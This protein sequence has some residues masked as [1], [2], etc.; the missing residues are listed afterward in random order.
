[1]AALLRFLL[2]V[3]SPFGHTGEI[4]DLEVVGRGRI[5]VP[6]G[7]FAMGAEAEELRAAARMCLQQVDATFCTPALFQ[8]E[9]PARR[10]RLSAYR[11]DATEVTN[12]AYGRCV[13]AGACT[14]ARVQPGDDRFRLPRAPVGSVSW[15]DARDYCRWAGGRLPT[16]AEWERA[17]RGAEGRRFPWGDLWNPH[18]CNHGQTGDLRDREDDGHRFVAPVGS[19]PGGRSPFGL[20]DL[21]GNVLEWVEDRYAEYSP[22]ARFDPVA[23]ETGIDRV[24]RGG[25]WRS[26]GFLARTTTR[27]HL[28]ETA[29]ELDVGFRCAE[30][31]R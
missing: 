9:A 25:S 21:A 6:A 10:V 27:Q 13:S 24:I 22:A 23:T 3:T 11:I 14:P 18:L 15:D 19:F 2:L 30:T 31:V 20:D 4:L 26:P 1:M 29:H 28:P 17:A 5:L 7:S 16:E 8:D 12:E